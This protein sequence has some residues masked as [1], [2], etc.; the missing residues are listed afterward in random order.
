M[1][2]Q[3][4]ECI[5][6]LSMIFIGCNLNDLFRIKLICFYD[7]SRMLQLY[8]FMFTPGS[9]VLVVFNNYLLKDAT[10][11]SKISSDHHR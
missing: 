7:P 3:L 11:R 5:E 4:H 2:Y 10:D 1:K 8:E 9:S 6:K